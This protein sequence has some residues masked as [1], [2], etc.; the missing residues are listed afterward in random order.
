MLCC[1]SSR[2]FVNIP[3]IL[4]QRTPNQFYRVQVGRF[5]WSSPPVNP[6]I[7]KIFFDMLAAVLGVVV[8]LESVAIWETAVDEWYQYFCVPQG[9]HDAI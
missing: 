7:S 9:V 4:L 1:N 8:L 2:F 3:K 5:R 6:V